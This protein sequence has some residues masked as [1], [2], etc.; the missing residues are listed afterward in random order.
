LA[1]SG[2]HYPRYPI[3]L[4]GNTAPTVFD[5]AGERGPGRRV[6]MLQW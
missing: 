2:H 6:C 5:A 3:A 4:L 1:A